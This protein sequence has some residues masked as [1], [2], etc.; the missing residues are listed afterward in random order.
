MAPTGDPDAQGGNRTDIFFGLNFELGNIH[1]LKAE[2]GIPI[3]Q[4][5][6]GPQMETKYMVNIFYQLMIM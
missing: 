1:S 5:L 3:Q 2:I 4:N 6:D